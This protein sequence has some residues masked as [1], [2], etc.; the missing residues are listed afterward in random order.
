MQEE[1]QKRKDSFI[2]Y[3]KDP[4]NEPLRLWQALRNW[5]YDE[6]KKEFESGDKPE[7]HNIY[8]GFDKDAC[9]DTFYWE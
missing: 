6:Y 8:A 5:A 2:A 3:L 4:K 9:E 7:I 1:R